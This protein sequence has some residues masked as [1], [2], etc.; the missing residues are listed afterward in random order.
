MAYANSKSLKSR[1]ED[2]DSGHNFKGQFLKHITYGMS[3]L[4]T[5]DDIN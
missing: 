3:A 5:A 1:D 2:E 4:W